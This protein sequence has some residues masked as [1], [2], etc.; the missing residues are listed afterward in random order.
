MC[1]NGIGDLRDAD[2]LYDF[3]FVRDLCEGLVVEVVRVRVHEGRDVSE[4]C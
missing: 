4:N 3:A 2:G 1:A